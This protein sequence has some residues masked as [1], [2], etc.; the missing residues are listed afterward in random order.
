MTEEPQARRVEVSFVRTPPAREVQAASGVEG[1]VLDGSV[2]RCV[3]YGSFQ[4]F[5]EALRG[6]EVINF[7][8]VDAHAR[9]TPTATGRMR[10][11]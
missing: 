8:A 10:S 6:H 9:P 7:T 4:S 3:V 11:K 1:V 2:L 5:L